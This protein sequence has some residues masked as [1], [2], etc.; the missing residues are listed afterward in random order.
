MKTKSLALIA[1][2]LVVALTLPIINLVNGDIKHSDIRTF[3]GAVQAAYRAD[4]VS[5]VPN[6][7]LSLVGYSSAPDDVVVG[8][9]GWLFLGD[10]YASSVSVK[11]G[12][13]FPS[14]QRF[15]RARGYRANIRDY[16][17][18]AGALDA[19][20]VI[21]PNK[22]DVYPEYLPG[23][24]STHD[25]P[26]FTDRL[27]KERD[28]T[29]IN[30]LPAMLESKASGELYYRTDS[31]WNTLGAWL[32]Y[33][34]I[35]EVIGTDHPKIKFLT[36]NDVRVDMHRQKRGGD[37]AAFLFIKNF[38]DDADPSVELGNTLA[39]ETKNL[40][41]RE[42]TYSGVNMRL[43][44]LRDPTLVRSDQALNNMRVIWLRD[45]FGNALSPFMAATFSEVYQQHWLEVLLDGDKLRKL[46]D[47]YHP[48]L[49]L[50]TIAGR[51][52][53]DVV[54]QS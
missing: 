28:H 7:A 50:V 25:K 11:R 40:K 26:N 35:A 37:L 22:A 24:M 14:E 49:L 13:I 4:H 33:R 12:L 34:H 9:D 47:E 31:H 27:L 53:V 54:R 5:G 38:R 16:A 3:R 51:S 19:Y 21:V 44:A 20:F 48:D 10:R 42:T 30:L 39:I 23:W 8:K 46:I 32:A 15:E 17:R 36:G 52:Y 2:A 29:L 6:F 45:S 1:V 43:H 41:T 18:S